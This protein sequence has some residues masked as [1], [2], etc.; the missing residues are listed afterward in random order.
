MMNGGADFSRK[1]AVITGLS[2]AIS[3]L[4]A[5][6]AL[7]L[8]CFLP[9]VT[10]GASLSALH[11][12]LIRMEK[13][14]EFQTARAFFSAFKRN[15]KQAT[16]LWLPFMLIFLAAA[17]DA[18]VLLAA[19]GL[20]PDWVMI[21]AFSAAIAAFLLFQ[22]VLPFQAYFENGTL[23]ILRCSAALAITNLP[24]TVAMA[25]VWLIPWALFHFVTLAWPLV[26]LFGIAG[27]GRF[28]AKLYVPVLE[29]LHEDAAER[30]Q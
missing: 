24:R 27:P 6:N 29:A 19:P 5:L 20:M 16:L 14:K 4:A 3:R 10:A 28:C 21:P 11:D 9:V 1:S 7:A 8:L 12:C 2:T 17:A 13:G 18:F 25:A 22:F 23:E 15:F 26:L 30:A